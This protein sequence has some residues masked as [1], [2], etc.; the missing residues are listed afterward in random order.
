MKKLRFAGL[1]LAVFAFGLAWCWYEYYFPIQEFSRLGEIQ[2]P[3]YTSVLDYHHDVGLLIGKFQLPLAQIQSFSKDNQLSDGK[4]NSDFFVADRCIHH[5]E[6][7]IQIRLE[8]KSGIAEI[9]IGL[10]DHSGDNPCVL[11]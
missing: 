1:I 4:S 8:K 2:F 11:N 9:E 10:P 6:N 5:G 7:S 3:K